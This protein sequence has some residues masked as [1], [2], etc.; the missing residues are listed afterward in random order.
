[1]FLGGNIGVPPL[2]FLPQLADGDLVVLELSNM[3]LIDLTVSPHVAVVLPVTPDHL[4]WHPDIDEYYAAKTSIAAYQKPGDVVAYAARNPVAAKI[5]EAGEGRKVPFGVPERVHAE[6]GGIYDGTTRLLDLSDSPL[7][8][9]HNA[10]NLTAAVAATFDLLG[11]DAALLREGV[12]AIEPLAHRL[13]PAGEAGGVTYVNDSL[14][15]TPETARAAMAAFPVPKVMI[16]GGSSKGL[17]FAALAEAVAKEDIRG[18]VLVGEVGPRI[19]AALDEAGI[20]GH[21]TVDG[22]MTEIVAKAAALARPGDAV[23]LSPAC[24]SFGDYKN[25]ADRGDQFK[26]AVRA[27]PA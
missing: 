6:A 21:V 9:E 2:E 15:T 26:A 24:A 18:I 7:L 19:A 8:G 14:S 3:Q 1:V 27:L 23:L 22:P 12:R 16:F 25:Y 5:A 11:R 17:S 13:E 4:N 20:G 10:R